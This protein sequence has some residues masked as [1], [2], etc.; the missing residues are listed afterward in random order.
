[1]IGSKIMSTELG[2]ISE[3]V[4]KSFLNLTFN[5][6]YDD[7]AD[8]QKIFFSSDHYN[9]ALKGIPIVWYFDGMYEDLHQPSDSADKIDF[10][11]LE[12]IVRTIYTTA[13]EIAENAKRPKVDKTLPDALNK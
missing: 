6:T 13:W 4:N 9:Y 10:I 3:R 2:E 8:L 5:Y 12:K 11:K 7:S 1:V